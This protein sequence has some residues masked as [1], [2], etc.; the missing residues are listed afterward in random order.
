MQE[1]IRPPHAALVSPV[2]IVGAHGRMGAWHT[3]LLRSY[4]C[5]VHEIDRDTPEHERLEALHSASSVLISVPI[6]VTEEIIFRTIPEL[7]RDALLLDLT[8]LKVRPL[9]AMLKHP[10]EVLGLHP[11]CAPSEVGLL[12]QPIVVCRGRHGPKAEAF[13]D[14]LRGLGAHVH[15]MDAQQHDKLMAIVQGLH[16]FYAIAFAHSLKSLGVTP[17]ETL[18]VSSPVYELRMQLMARILGQDPQLYVDIELENPFVPEVLR[19]YAK[20]VEQFKD[21]IERGSRDECLAF[22]K[23]AAEAFGDYGHKALQQS[24]ILLALRQ[25]SLSVFAPAGVRS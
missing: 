2:T 11:M 22:F 19:S 21:A 24:D 17:E 16:H 10:G 23:E 25:Q 5:V 15:D 1:H 18:Q 7:T 20:S 8:S 3:T 9:A 13:I 4:G 6:S 12:N 14:I